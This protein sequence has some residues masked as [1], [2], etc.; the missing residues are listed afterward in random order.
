MASEEGADPLAHLL[1][2]GAGADAGCVSCKS[3]LRGLLA[4][5]SDDSRLSEEARV[6]GDTNS[7]LTSSSITHIL[8]S[9]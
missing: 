6:A 8:G 7:G 3:P 9:S 1:N 4:S 5:A 2:F